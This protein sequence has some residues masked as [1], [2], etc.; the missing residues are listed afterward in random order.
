MLEPPIRWHCTDVDPITLIGPGYSNFQVSTQAAINSSSSSVKN[1]SAAYVSVCARVQKPFSHW[2][3][4]AS[5]YCLRLHPA[6]DWSLLAGSHVIASGPHSIGPHSSPGTSDSKEGEGTSPHSQLTLRVDGTLLMASINGKQVAQLHDATYD[7]GPAALGSGYHYAS[8]HSF[9]MTALA[10][11]QLT[12]NPVLR[13][14][15][16]DGSIAVGY[17]VFTGVSLS[18]A[19]RVGEF[20]LAFTALKSVTVTSLARFAAAGS[21]GQH[22]LSIYCG[23]VNAS[24]PDARCQGA[25][26]TVQDSMGSSALAM[27]AVNFSQSAADSTGLVWALLSSP[28]DAVVGQ[29]YFLVSE[30]GATESSGDR[31]YIG[32]ANYPCIGQPGPGGTLPKL[33]VQVD[34]LR[35]DGGISRGPGGKWSEVQW[36]YRPRSFGPLSFAITS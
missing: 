9:E 22:K 26:S 1:A 3:P 25:A 35:I 27:V 10:D 16:P 28:F 17:P 19:T 20:G 24:Q 8:F 12:D 4:A 29:Q 32:T 18:N 31:F 14:A 15:V 5:G 30:E 7:N 33:D 11:D 23:A 6:G 2:C 21:T 13:S 36:D 34:S